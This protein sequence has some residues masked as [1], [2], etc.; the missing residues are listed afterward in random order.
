MKKEYP[1]WVCEKCGLKHG[2][3]PVG[4]ACWHIDTCGICG[5]SAEVTE[6][7]DFGHL[8]YGWEQGEM[9]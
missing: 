6:P 8:K 7:R 4:I 1:V 5:E 3:R 9:K 2:N